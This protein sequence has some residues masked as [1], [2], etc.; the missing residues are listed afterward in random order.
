MKVQRIKMSS[1]DVLLT[2]WSGGAA[3]EEYVSAER[4]RL[5]DEAPWEWSALINRMFKYLLGQ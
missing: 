5:Y 4:A 2:V 1:G 3:V